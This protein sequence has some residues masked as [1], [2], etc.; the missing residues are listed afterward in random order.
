[1]R[2]QIL[3]LMLSFLYLSIYAQE[4]DKGMVYGNFQSD[5]QYY[6]RDST[7]T[8]QSTEPQEKSAFN[9]YLNVFYQRGKFLIGV[10]YE[11]YY[12]ALLGY[13]INL[14][15]N[16]IA[17]R[18]ITYQDKDIEI[19]AGNFYEQFGS[20]SILRT[21]EERPLGIDNSIDGLRVVYNFQ[22]KARIKGVFGRQ[23]DGFEL[24]EGIVRGLDAEVYL[25]RIGKNEDDV[26]K[27]R[28]MVGGS[29]VSK[30]QA[31]DGPT[32]LDELIP[33]NV[34]AFAGRFEVASGKFNVSGEYVHKNPD[35]SIINGGL[36]QSTLNLE[37]GNLQILTGSYSKR[38]LGF[39]VTAKRMYNMDFRSDR[40]AI[41]NRL[42]TNFV[43]ANTIQHTY[44]L[45]TWYPYA[46]Q[47][48]PGEMSVQAD[49]FYKIKKNTSLGGKYG[50]T[51][52]VNYALVNS[53]DSANR[54]QPGE[55]RY[56][57]DFNT[58]VT[59]KWSKKLKSTF[60]YVYLQYDK[61]QVEGQFGVGLVESNTVIADVLY[62]FKKKKS[63]RME[64]QHMATP[65][66]VG[67]WAFGLLE[68]GIAPHWFFYVSDEINYGTFERQIPVN[69][70]N[71]GAVYLNGANRFEVRYGRQRAGLICVGGICRVVP[72]FTG[73]TFSVTSSF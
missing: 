18:F 38:G 15:G 64:L 21:L 68:L 39:T 14:V 54:W 58:T 19:T 10:R 60:K 34:D 6:V 69:Y 12:P 49:L 42:L 23:R 29:Y 73:L 2:K 65:Q 24:S 27:I 53:L 63:I 56:F 36:S 40:E 5:F 20:G 67:N 3:T 31:Y 26:S 47:S 46:A 11:G 17:N 48:A 25:D 70:Y 55:R 1:M 13:P 66:D 59:K 52:S 44:R 57:Q 33:K 16:G 30:F 41:D 9:G 71:F 62:K 43:T 28:V 50:M 32:Q 4:E 37:S 51:I 22:D 35:P 45:L 72:P 61:D 7:A 8:F